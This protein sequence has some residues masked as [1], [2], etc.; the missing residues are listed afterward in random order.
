VRFGSP[1]LGVRRVRAFGC[2]SAA[3]A[4]IAVPGCFGRECDGITAEWGLAPNQGE[5]LDPDTWESSPVDGKW[6]KF[7]PKSTWVLHVPSWQA[8][9][10]EPAEFFAYVSSAESPNDG[11]DDAFPNWTLA[12]GNLAEFQAA[13]PG[14]VNVHNDTCS[15]YYVRVVLRAPLAATDAGAP[16][17]SP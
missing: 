8:S 1:P 13:F 5:F 3:V 14:R 6:L 4:A 10:R 7:G 11:G 16:A 15:Q 2:A 17:S 12:V 9:G